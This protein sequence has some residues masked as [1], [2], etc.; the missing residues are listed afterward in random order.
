MNTNSQVDGQSRTY[1]VTSST[2]DIPFV[3]VGWTSLWYVW[4]APSLNALIPRPTICTAPIESLEEENG[5]EQEFTNYSR[6][7]SEQSRYLF[8]LISL[9][10]YPSSFL[11]QFNPS[12]PLS[13][14]FLFSF[15]PRSSGTALL[16]V[17]TVIVWLMLLPGC[18]T[19]RCS[20]IW[21]IPR[22]LAP[23][24]R[25]SSLLNSLAHMPKLCLTRGIHSTCMREWTT[26]WVSAWHG[27]VKKIRVGE[28]LPSR[29]GKNSLGNTHNHHLRCHC[30][31]L[32]RLRARSNRSWC[33]MWSSFRLRG[34]FWLDPATQR[35][36]CCFG[37]ISLD[38]DKYIYPGIGSNI[39]E[40]SP[41]PFITGF[42]VVHLRNGDG[43]SVKAILR[44]SVWNQ[45]THPSAMTLWLAGIGSGDWW[46]NDPKC[47]SRSAKKRIAFRTSG[48]QTPWTRNKSFW[49]FPRHTVVHWRAT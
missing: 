30:W 9:S 18:L 28:D 38:I 44:T 48:A 3:H 39:I 33:R 6:F 5:K 27:K 29:K 42:N 26:E 49:M 17:Y 12:F 14:L 37:W 16:C 15:I 34:S 25:S 7:P 1:S 10:P 35:T 41:P 11:F 24:K 32:F 13:L 36:V 46:L 20:G 21:K 2:A 43:L 23:W 45:T 31:P 4:P 19:S 40:P 47:P 22:M 8:R